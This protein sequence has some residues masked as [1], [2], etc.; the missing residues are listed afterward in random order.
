MRIWSLHPKYLDTKGL[1]ALWRE[2]LLAKHVLEGKTIGY[3]NTD[4][5]FQF[6][7]HF[8]IFPNP[9]TDRL[10]V[11]YYSKDNSKNTF[12]IFDMMGRIIEQGNFR[13]NKG[14]GTFSHDINMSA[15]IYL[16]K[17]ESNVQKFVV[18]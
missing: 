5:Q 17:I 15:G 2:A 7:N 11:E 12:E 13:F 4:S 9:V 14:Y 10:N 8:S 1:V 16:I 3:L 18:K 6:N